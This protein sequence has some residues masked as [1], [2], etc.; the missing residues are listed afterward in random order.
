MDYDADTS[1]ND[2]DS[3]IDIKSSSQLTQNAIIVNTAAIATRL[4][5][6]PVWYVYHDTG[7]I[8]YK[9]CDSRAHKYTQIDTLTLT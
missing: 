4:T 8:I 3:D 6:T 2:A 7:T 1:N 5:L 9:G